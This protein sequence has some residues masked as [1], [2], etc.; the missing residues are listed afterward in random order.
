VS[1]ATTTNYNTACL[2]LQARSQDHAFVNCRQ[3]GSLLTFPDDKLTLN[4]PAHV[5]AAIRFD[6]AA[7]HAPKSSRGSSLQFEVGRTADRDVGLSRRPKRVQATRMS[8]LRLATK[9]SRDL[10]QETL[11]VAYQLCLSLRYTHP[12]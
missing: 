8:L 3:L 9:L 12:V 7:N 11:R 1:F 5:T 4:G 2:V 10:S 6:R